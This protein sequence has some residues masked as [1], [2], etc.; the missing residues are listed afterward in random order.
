M[1]LVHKSEGAEDSAEH[2]TSVALL[3]MSS[4]TEYSL[5]E[6]DGDLKFVTWSS[7]CLDNILRSFS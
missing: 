1:V 6:K 4:I 5:N 7:K 3:R 2:V